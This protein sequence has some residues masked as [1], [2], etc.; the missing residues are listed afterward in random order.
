[1][2]SHLLIWMQSDEELLSTIPCCCCPLFLMTKVTSKEITKQKG[3]ENASLGNVK[4][5]KR[6]HIHQYANY[7][8]KVVLDNL[9]LQNLKTTLSLVIKTSNTHLFDQ[10]SSSL[11]RSLREALCF[12]SNRSFSTLAASTKTE[13]IS[14]KSNACHSYS[15]QSQSHCLSGLYDLY[16]ERSSPS[17]L[18]TF[19]RGK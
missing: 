5:S 17:I 8:V 9:Y 14:I 7:G 12:S 1:M 16:I 19:N 2:L 18:A 10:S 11:E 6:L 3:K 13:N 15:P 4:K